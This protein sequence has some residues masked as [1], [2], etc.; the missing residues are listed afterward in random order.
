[1]IVESS[2]PIHIAVQSQHID[3]GGTIGEPTAKD[4]T[5][6]LDVEIVVRGEYERDHAEC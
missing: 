2:D 1:M 3:V 6:R 5:I 4:I